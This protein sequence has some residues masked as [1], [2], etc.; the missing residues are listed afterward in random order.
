MATNSGILLTRAYE[1]RRERRL[2]DAKQFFAEAIELCRATGDEK[3]LAQ[4]L[5]GMGQIERDLQDGS[6][7]RRH[8]EEAVTVCRTLGDDLKLAHT[9]RH[10]GD[11]LRHQEERARA[12]SCYREALQIYRQH[13]GA[14]LLDLANTIR[15]FALLK[16]NNGETQEALA[17]WREAKTLYTK[18]NVQDGVTES[19]HYLSQLSQA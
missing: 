16:G 9:I 12:E 3:S 19:D 8:Y 2:D 7:A 18:V 13:E 15:G 14:S 6:S 11:V 5:A 10:L 1:A 17:L 4:A